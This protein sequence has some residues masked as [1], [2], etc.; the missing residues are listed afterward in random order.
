MSNLSDAFVICLI[1]NGEVIGVSIV[2]VNF[3]CRG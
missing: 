1:S 3:D 2:I